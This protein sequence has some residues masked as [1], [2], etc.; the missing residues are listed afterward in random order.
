MYSK[1]RIDDAQKVIDKIA[2]WNKCLDQDIKLV[3]KSSKY[4]EED[5]DEVVEM[6]SSAKL[7]ADNG[8]R[9]V[10]TKGCLKILR[11]RQ[12]VTVFAVC[13]FNW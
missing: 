9:E 13:A 8:K 3:T 4:Q 6:S 12:F 2:R 5:E 10:T 11:S 1:G 7:D